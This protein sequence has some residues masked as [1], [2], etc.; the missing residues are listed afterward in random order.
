M[1][2]VFGDVEITNNISGQG[3]S[4]RRPAR[5]ATTVPGTFTTSFAN[6]Q[7]IDGVLLVTGDRILI[8]NQSSGIENGVYIV[9]STGAPSRTPDYDDGDA[10][11][12]SFIFIQEGTDNGMTGWLCINIIGSDI[13]ST[14]PL[15]FSLITGDISGQGLSTDNAIVRWDGITGTMIQ[16]SSILIDDSNNILGLQYLQFSNITA[17]SNPA[18]GE[19]R[20]YKKADDGLFWKPDAAGPEVDLTTKTIIVQDEG[21]GVISTPHSTLNFVGAGVSVTNAGS[22]VATVSIAGSSAGVTTWT[23]STTGL[24]PNTPTA[25]AITL[26]GTLIAGNG[27]TGFNNYAVGDII[28]ANTSTTFAKLPDVVT[29]NVLISGGVG[30]VPSYGKV[31]LTTHISGVLP[32][33]NGGTNLST[34]PTNGQLLIGNGTGYTLSTITAGTAIGVAN[35]SGTITI[36]NNGVTS[37]TTNTGL[38]TNVSATGEVT[39]TNTGVTSWSAGTTGLTPNTFTNGAVTLSG[40]LIAANGGTG[41]NSYVVGDIITANT[42]STF[43][44]ISDIATGN[45]LRSGG[46]GVVPSYGKVGLTTHISG[47]LP[48]ANGGTNLSTTPTNGRLLIGNGSGYT[49]ANLTAGTAIGITNGSGSIT[50]ENTGVTSLNTNTGLSTNVSATGAVTVTNTGVTSLT[51]NTGLSTNVSATGAVTVTNTGVTSWS[52]GTTGLTPNTATT[53]SVTLSGTLIAANGGTGFNSYAVGDIITANSSTTFAKLSDIATGNV[54]LSGG[55]GVVPAYGKVGLTTHVSGVLPITNGG[56]NLSATP[57]NGQLLIGNGTGYTLATLTSGTGISVTNGSGAITIASTGLRNVQDE[58]VVLPGTPHNTL[59]FTGVGVT[60]TNAGSSVAT[61]NIPGFT[62]NTLTPQVQTMVVGSAGTQFNISSVTA[63]HTFNLPD[64]SEINTGVVTNTQQIIKGGK[65]FVKD[66]PLVNFIGSAVNSGTNISSLTINVPAGS[67]TTDM[68]MLAFITVR[69][70]FSRTNNSVSYTDDQ[71]IANPPAG[72]I[73]VNKTINLVNYPRSIFTYVKTVSGSEPGSY[74]WNNIS[75]GPANNFTGAGTAT[76]STNVMNVTSV[77]SGTF[78]TGQTVT[79]TGVSSGTTI[80]GFGSGNG[81]TGT[82]TLSTSPGTLSSRAVSTTVPKTNF[83]V[84]GI[85]TYSNVATYNSI[86]VLGAQATPGSLTHSTRTAPPII[87]TN[88]NTLLITY[89]SY[90]SVAGSWTLNSGQSQAANIGAGSTGTGPQAIGESM[91]QG[92]LFNVPS[93]TLPQYS[94]TASNN[95]D[96][97]L[98][99]V[100]ALSQSAEAILT[101]KSQCGATS[102]PNTGNNISGTTL[103][104]A[105]AVTGSFT[106]GMKIGGGTILS[107]TT[108]T[109]FG[110]GSG[111]LGTYIV[112]PSQTTTGTF[113]I[114]GDGQLTNM[115]D[116]VDCFGNLLS[117][118]DTT[119][120]P[121]LGGTQPAAA[122]VASNPGNNISGSI[123]TVTGAVTGLLGIDMVITGGSII[124]NTRII[125]FG[126]GTGGTGTY[127]VTPVQNTTAG[128]FAINGIAR[129]HLITF[130]TETTPLLNSYNVTIPSANTILVGTDYAQI[131]SNKNMTDN[132]NNL[133]ARALWYGTGSGSVST[134]AAVAPTSGQV[135]TATS[136]T[137]ATWQSISGG[138]NKVTKGG[139]TDTATLVVGTNDAFDF[140]LET[141][142]TTR[143]VIQADGDIQL[144]PNTD[145]FV[146]IGTN[147]ASAPLGFFDV[148]RVAVGTTNHIRFTVSDDPNVD[149]YN[150]GVDTVDTGSVT[151]SS[152]D[153]SFRQAMVMATDGVGTNVVFGFSTSVNSGATWNPRIALQQTGNFGIGTNDPSQIL[154]VIGN[155]QLTGDLHDANDN[156]IINLSETASAVNEFTIANAATGNP[157]TLSATG[158]DANVA[159]SIQPK[160]ATGTVLMG[161]IRHYG[162]LATNPSSPTPSDGDRYYNTTIH[163]EMIYD[164]SRS[165]WLSGTVL[166]EGVGR[167][168]TNTASTYY[169]RFNGMVESPSEGAYCQKGTIIFIS[170]TTGRA[171]NHTLEILRN[172]VVIGSLA[173]GGAAIAVNN[174][175]NIDFDEG[176]ISFRNSAG[177]DTT[178]NLQAVI[179]YKLRA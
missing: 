52:A 26:G 61:V 167:N 75:P 146:T 14:N 79:A 134:Y 78:T 64:A 51:T 5:L 98:S 57:I 120:Q 164:N 143:M 128:S 151:I 110:S 155:I 41:F 136:G 7:S 53:G 27:G 66:T 18:A 119:G 3:L 153:G 118:F 159:I 83:V 31:G 127:T 130:K 177:S 34:T 169:R 81:G 109:A 63:Q 32:V 42:T 178:R 19:G 124:P 163:H 82:Y 161:N 140:N 105:G 68:L 93:G 114:I 141:N 107:N 112:N 104:I 44:K 160:G 37:L 10:V 111:G 174:S 132:S 85:S 73:L 144:A 23:G 133:I 43:E 87:T 20:L 158:N 36:S 76:F 21:S 108:I 149:T 123:L 69:N 2:L 150:L 154:D 147:A 170:M 1:S 102:D 71:V 115:I 101:T 99:I 16:D 70:G 28:T 56:T 138:S 86:N 54:L 60:S 148:R 137:T 24:T 25:G 97:G 62:L 84:G 126:T 40:T 48:I 92:Y 90:G 175:A 35:G 166:N 94:A 46:V 22:G 74:T 91:V 162:A 15:L 100:V 106:I 50:I 38:S 12:E 65:T 49:L 156:E 77:S 172:G 9:E 59:N 17:P 47:V 55:V 131:I 125:G 95:G 129:N 29:G 165:K 135:L 171:D 179:Y 121:F 80:T 116:N 8:K 72:W 157:P 13:V 96:V 39:V 113:G 33:T 4:S 145:K 142:N 58:G 117:G 67:T 6:G 139:D 89:Y 103:T 152:E 45:V 122:S 168:G 11:S 173:S 30:V 88:N 176:V